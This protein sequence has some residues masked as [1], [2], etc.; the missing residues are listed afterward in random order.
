[1][2]KISVVIP[3]LN[4][5]KT[6]R[7]AIERLK[8]QDMN[9]EDFEI[10]VSD[11][12][13]T[14]GTSE[15]ARAAGAD[16][17]VFQPNKGTNFARQKGF[18]SAEGKLVAFLDADNAPPSNWLTRACAIF[19][20]NPKAGI[21]SGP[22]EYPESG[23][24]FKIVSTFYQSIVIPIGAHVI[25]A[26][27][28]ERGVAALGGNMVIKREILEKIGG[29]DTALTFWGDDSDTAI[30]ISRSGAKSIYRPDFTVKSS[31]RRFNKKGLLRT[32]FGYTKAYIKVYS[33]KG[34]PISI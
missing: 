6:I 17:V 11:N 9:R 1:M 25:G 26:F 4:E 13:S 16:K 20:K 2:K 18:E 7:A 8:K 27:F 22:Y 19:E 21:L 29:F 5:E 32:V 34:G 15:A 12:G 3:A 31:T 14:D 23:I 10:I 30:R 24:P 33:R 28:G